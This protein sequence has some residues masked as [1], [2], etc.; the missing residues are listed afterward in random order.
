MAR[1]SND[2]LLPEAG[3]AR[4]QTTQSSTSKA[5]L[6]VVGAVCLVSLTLAIVFLVLYTHTRSSKNDL[7][8]KL[9]AYEALCGADGCAPAAVIP[10]K[11]PGA[12]CPLPPPEGMPTPAQ[13]A[14]SVRTTWGSTS[15]ALE[16]APGASGAHIRSVKELPS[17]LNGE[18]AM[19]LAGGS[20]EVLGF[21]DTDAEFIQESTFFYL[22]GLDVPDLG[23]LGI[24][25]PSAP[26]G[27]DYTL[28]VPRLADSYAVW[29]GFIWSL[30]EWKTQSG[31][32]QV[33]YLDTLPAILTNVTTPVGPAKTI[34]TLPGSGSAI[35]LPAQSTAT[36]DQASANLLASLNRARY[37]KTDLELAPLRRASDVS[38]KAHEVLMAGIRPGWYEYDAE[39]IFRLTNGLCGNLGQSYLPIVGAGEHGAILHYI[40]NDALTKDG[41]LLLID[42]A[43]N[44]MRYT[45]DITRTYPVNGKFTPDQIAIYET[46]LAAQEAAVATL[47]VGSTYGTADAAAKRAMA[48]GLLEAG[49][50]FGTVDSVLASGRLSLFYLHGL[51]HA[52]GLDVHDP[53][54]G[55]IPHNFVGTIEPGIYFN[56]AK[57]E[58][59]LQDPII[60]TVVNGTRVQQFLDSSFG[61]VRIEDVYLVQDSGVECL[62]CRAPKNVSSIEAVMTS[63]DWFPVN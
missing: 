15:R 61:G 38:A 30:D 46:V 62:S 37:S 8:N 51:G 13:I 3:Y 50:F 26:G 27:M 5:V 43:A 16:D 31:F 1:N 52:V 40:S 48:E 10:S 9:A 18:A 7:E 59:V 54:P 14:A 34:Y 19:Y 21:S 4:T 32:S 41:D 22:T 47:A 25:N 6:A 53:Q 20:S 58:P 17:F 45:S 57:L 12:A 11:D 49:I 2:A 60:L 28:L 36:I 39:S 63:N 24:P 35:P 42:A 29:N 55:T 23:L 56:A 33:A 44:E